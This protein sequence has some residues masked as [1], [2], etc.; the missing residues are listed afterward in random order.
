MENIRKKKAIVITIVCILVLI[1]L[2][3]LYLLSH[4]TSIKYNDWLV[5]GH[6]YQQVKARYGE[7]DIEYEH[8]VAYKLNDGNQ[9]IMPSHLPEYYWMVFDDDGII[10]KV[11]VDT[12][13]GG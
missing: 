3:S 5:V 6:S 7:F 2:V 13:P 1:V 11:Y 10:I 9:I 8:S 4:K 12:I